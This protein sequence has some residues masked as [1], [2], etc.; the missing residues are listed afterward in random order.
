LAKVKRFLLE[1]AWHFNIYFCLIVTLLGILGVYPI[2]IHARN[3]TVI[4]F[5]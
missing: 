1:N 4:K 5:R 2:G 3:K